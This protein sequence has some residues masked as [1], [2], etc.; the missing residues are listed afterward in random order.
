[1]SSE[2]KACCKLLQSHYDGE[3]ADGGI[4]AWEWDGNPDLRSRCC[5]T[6]GWSSGGTCT[7]WGPPVPPAMPRRPTT[8]PA[9]RVLEVA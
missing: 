1:V 6:L 3:L 9:A 2:T 5:A 7:P 8:P 4:G